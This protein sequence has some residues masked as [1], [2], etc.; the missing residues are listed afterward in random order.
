MIQESDMYWA[1][2]LSIS[3]MCISDLVAIWKDIHS[4]GHAQADI[5]DLTP[6]P[7]EGDSTPQPV[8][9]LEISF[10]PAGTHL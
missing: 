1:S 5:Q 4:H 3:W 8:N 9:Q 10:L 7:A 2:V 6:N